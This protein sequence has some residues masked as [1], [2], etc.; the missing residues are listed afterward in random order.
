MTNHYFHTLEPL[1][2][3]LIDYGIATE[4]E[5]TLV[6]Q[7]NGLTLQTLQD[8]LYARTGHRNFAQHIEE[9]TPQALHETPTLT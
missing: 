2:Q 4:N 3:Y 9:H 7:I 1:W 5:L 8:I 6:T